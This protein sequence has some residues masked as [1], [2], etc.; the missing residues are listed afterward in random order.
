[1]NQDCYLQFYSPNK[2][3]FI[4][5][6]AN[7]IRLGRALLQTEEDLKESEI[8][9]DTLPITFQLKPVAYAS[10]SLMNTEQKLFKY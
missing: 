9:D 7:K 4:E 6:D 3:L 5:T 10:K 1:M 2:P 8:E